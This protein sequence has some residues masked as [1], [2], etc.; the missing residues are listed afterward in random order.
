MKYFLNLIS[1]LMLS[2]P[3]LEKYFCE[4]SEF[5]ISLFSYDCVISNLP[6]DLL[7]LAAVL[8]MF[9][10]DFYFNREIYSCCVP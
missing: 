8:N 2:K 1:F 4:T 9:S 6:E 5:C 10:S 3:Y 7:V